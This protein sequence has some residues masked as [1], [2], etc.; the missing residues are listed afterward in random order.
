M[1]NL[2]S[3]LGSLFI[4]G[5]VVSLLSIA[6]FADGE[7]DPTFGNSGGV[8]VDLSGSGRDNAAGAV[9]IQPD[10][11]IIVAGSFLQSGVDWDFGVMRLNSDGSIDSSFG[12]N[13]RTLKAFDLIPAG[14]DFLE[15][16]ALRS[17]GSILLGGR[18]AFDLFYNHAMFQVLSDGSPDTS[19]APGGGFAYPTY[20]GQSYMEAID[21]SSVSPWVLSSAD[22]TSYGV[23][24]TFFVDPGSGNTPVEYVWPPPAGLQGAAYDMSLVGSS[25]T[26]LDR[27]YYAGLLAGDGAFDLAVAA[28]IEALKVLDTSFDG[29]GWRRVRAESAGGD[30]NS[31]GLTVERYFGNRLVAGGFADRTGG[32]DG[33]VVRLFDDGAP[34]PS[35]GANGQQY[36]AWDM[37]GGDDDEVTDI[38]VQGDGF[39]VLAATTEIAS[40]YI[41]IIARLDTA[42]AYDS[43]FASNGWSPLTSPDGYVLRGEPLIALQPNGYL[44]VAVRAESTS[45]GTDRIFVTRLTSS[46]VVFHD[47]FESGD[48]TAWTL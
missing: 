13:G 16:A 43:T 18:A 8:I 2:K 29:D 40:G 25:S 14:E 28:E 32:L 42:G 48:T 46:H 9:L 27:R 33:F 41:P 37:G 17:D 30:W 1:E 35:F 15:A 11:K 24:G 7:P 39:L 31:F 26:G 21:G 4:T 44:V 12:T 10:G 23:V 34:D 36:V 38:V 3:D 45:G 5:W 20:Q 22:S 47:G 6:A 19:F